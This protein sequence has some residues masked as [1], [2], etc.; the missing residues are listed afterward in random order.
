M[1]SVQPDPSVWVEVNGEHVVHDA[2]FQAGAGKE[3]EM[4]L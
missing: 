4:F 2:P 3:T 1:T